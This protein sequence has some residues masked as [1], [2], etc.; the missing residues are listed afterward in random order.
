MDD[1]EWIFNTNFSAEI[2]KYNHIRRKKNLQAYFNIF[3][4]DVKI[5]MSQ[6]KEASSLKFQSVRDE[7]QMSVIICWFTDMNKNEASIHCILSLQ[8]CLEHIF[9]YHDY[10]VTLWKCVTFPSLPILYY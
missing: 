7:S 4:I 2:M 10:L 5:V 9:Y 6:E 3:T 1:S 8:T